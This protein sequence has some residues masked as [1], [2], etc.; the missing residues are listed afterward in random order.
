MFFA[1]PCSEG[2]QFRQVCGADIIFSS[3]TAP[4]YEVLC[5][6][7]LS[8]FPASGE[9]G[10]QSFEGW[11]RYRLEGLGFALVAWVASVWKYL[12]G[13]GARP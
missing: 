7:V 12:W 3:R 8:I 1:S 2:W 4:P 5:I 10:L 11:D 6:P 13:F 9:A